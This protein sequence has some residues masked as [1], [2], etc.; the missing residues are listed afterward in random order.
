MARLYTAEEAVEMVMDPDPTGPESAR[1]ESDTETEDSTTM[2]EDFVPG[3]DSSSTS[4]TDSADTE[5]DETPDTSW[6]SKNGEI[7]W[8]P[9]NSETFRYNSPG[10]KLRP[11]PT[12]Y[13]VSRVDDLTD[14]FYL[15]FTEE[16]TEVITRCTNLH[17]SRTVQG[18][19]DLDATT[20]RAYFG[21]LLLAGVYRSRGETTRS[22]WDGDTGRHIFRATMSRKTFETISRSLRFDDHLSRPR[23]RDDDKLAAIRKIWD[24][25]TDQ[26][27]RIFNPGANVCVDEQ[28]VLYRGKCNFLQYIPNRP[29]RYGFKIWATCDVTTSYV[30]RLSIYTGQ[31][32]EKHQGQSVVL[33]MTQGLSGVT[34]TCDHF[35]SYGLAAQMLKKKIAMVGTMRK[36]KAELPP[37]LLRVQGREC[38]SSVFAFAATHTVV[39]YIPK[40]GK[41][42]LV[43]STKHRE[44]VIS[45]GTKKEPQIILDYN[46]CKRGVETMDQ[47]IAAHSCRRKTKRWPLA[48]FFNMLDIS[49]L[50][51][52]IV[53]TAIDP[54]WNTG[55]AYRRR[56]FLEQLGKK[57][58][59]PQMTRRQ[60][61]PQIPE[62]I[63]LIVQAQTSSGDL[64]V[65]SPNPLPTAS[66]TRR[67]QC[68][69][70]PTRKVC[71]FS[72]KNCGKGVCKTHFSAICSSCLP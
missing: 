55:K 8:A 50:N 51:A 47:I 17:G 20:M 19:K 28:L 22:L 1:S 67:K 34:V 71:T 14:A 70:C 13:A 27:P 69:L 21:L 11:G 26:L 64:T 48:I 41:N 52:C 45:S 2:D 53:W 42:M 59:M 18:W 49:A 62:A 40:R 31:L 63:N 29:G 57:L 5:E 72:C 36:N 9:T 44:S 24:Q 7:S 15:F 66:H 39:S 35:F 60:H 12:R 25:W 16:I 32:A 56:L 46:R 23:R 30:W 54:S 4:S 68:V 33:E 65:D 61:L 58:V 3:P 10:T 38:F 6:R 43:L 37:K